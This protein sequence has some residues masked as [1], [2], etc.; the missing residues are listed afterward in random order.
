MAIFVACAHVLSCRLVVADV[1]LVHSNVFWV[2][3]WISTVK[4]AGASSG[5]VMRDVVSFFY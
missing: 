1:L 2:L 4:D 3:G 5:A